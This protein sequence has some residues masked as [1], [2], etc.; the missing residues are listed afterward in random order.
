MLLFGHIGIAAGV[1]KVCEL[2]G[3]VDEV[4][5]DRKSGSMRISP[6]RLLGKIGDRTGAVD[7]RLV[8]IGSLLPDIVDKPLWFFGGVFASGRDF[9]HTFLFNLVLLFGGIALVRRGK[10]G[11]L[12]VSLVSFMHLILDEI[13]KSPA[14][15][16]W[17]L[18]GPFPEVETS[19][20]L[21]NIWQALISD[22]GVYIP[23]A[24]G[25]IIIIVFAGK[26]IAGKGVTRFIRTGVIG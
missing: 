4:A 22:P 5:E 8:I 24:V 2:L 20:W 19:T 15:L 1:V 9:S 23:E 7:Y 26:A 11:L 17:P 13:W 10:S 16:W 21:P 6:R 18:L 25:F 3:A 14:T 12:V